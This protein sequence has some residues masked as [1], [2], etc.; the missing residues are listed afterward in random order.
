MHNEFTPFNIQK[1]S[2]HFSHGS[3]L[4]RAV[5]LGWGAEPLTA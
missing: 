2:R 3:I 4:W 5:G 1:A